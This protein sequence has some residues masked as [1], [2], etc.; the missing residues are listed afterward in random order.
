M[1]FFIKI[2][3]WISL[4]DYVTDTL[5]SCVISRVVKLAALTRMGFRISVLVKLKSSFMKRE[6]AATDNLYGLLWIIIVF[7]PWLCLCFFVYFW[8][9]Y[10]SPYFVLL[11]I[12]DET[13]QHVHFGTRFG[14][15]W[16]VCMCWPQTW[17]YTSLFSTLYFWNKTRTTLGWSC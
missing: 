3:Y 16:H 8:T 11:L 10:F 4:I 5:P 7:I 12:G 17:F 1:V 6:K 15:W 13:D 9:L 14:S 2:K